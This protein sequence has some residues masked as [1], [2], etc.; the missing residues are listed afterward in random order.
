M[1]ASVRRSGNQAG[2]GMANTCEL[3]LNALK[4]KG[5]KDADRPL[6]KMASR[7]DIPL[8]PGNTRTEARQA[9]RQSLTH[10]YRQ[11]GGTE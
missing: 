7:R 3:L 4:P 5:P 1:T 9:N 6:A 11:S 10:S 2:V 8:Y